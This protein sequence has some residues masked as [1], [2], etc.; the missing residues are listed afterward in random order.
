MRSRC[1]R[2]IATVWT[3]VVI[4]ACLMIV[5]LVLD[6]G[7]ILRARST[8]FDLAGGA[9]RAGAQQLSQPA[10]A[11]GDVVLDPDAARR[12]ALTWLEAR[13]SSGAVT[14][15]GDRVTVTVQ[16]DV[17]LQILQPAS[18]TVSETST[19]EARRGDT[20]P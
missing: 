18:V 6:G 15:D 1:D 5:G 8:A 9:A 11:Q 17:E 14:V 4:G 2:G 3:A 13:D 7:T 16:H 10:L 19:A 20:Q 12:A